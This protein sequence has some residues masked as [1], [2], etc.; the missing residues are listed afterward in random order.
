MWPFYLRPQEIF[1][2]LLHTSALVCRSVC[3][4]ASQGVHLSTPSSAAKGWDSAMKRGES[5]ITR[6][7]LSLVGGPSCCLILNAQQAFKEPRNLAEEC[8]DV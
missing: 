6:G 8:L 2:L 3:S 4:S 5:G 7:W 1:I